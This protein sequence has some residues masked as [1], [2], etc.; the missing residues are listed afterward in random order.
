MLN[1]KSKR[2]IQSSDI[3]QLQLS[4]FFLLNL[5]L[6]SVNYP[7]SPCPS[8]DLLL[9][10]LLCLFS[11]FCLLLFLTLL[12]QI[13]NPT[14]LTLLAISNYIFMAGFVGLVGFAI[15]LQYFANE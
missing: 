6:L 9:S 4:T 1:L 8:T 3:S 5:I 13:T 12:P 11:S 10:L 15:Y 7:S 14:L 2:K